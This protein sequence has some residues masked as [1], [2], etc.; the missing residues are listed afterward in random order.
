[1]VLQKRM[2][3]G[4]V[5]AVGWE[6]IV[7]GGSCLIFSGRQKMSSLWMAFHHLTT[8]KDRRFKVPA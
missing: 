4:A 2:D 6:A 3:V 1:M 5:A 7:R 8:Q